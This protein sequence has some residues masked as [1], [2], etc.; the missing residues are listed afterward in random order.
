MEIEHSNDMMIENSPSMA[1]FTVDELCV[2]LIEGFNN[3]KDRFEKNDLSQ[4][5]RAKLIECLI[6]LR[7]GVYVF[8]NGILGK[9][10]NMKKCTPDRRN[11]LHIASS[12]LLV[13]APDTELER[14]FIRIFYT[15]CSCRLK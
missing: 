3:F 12:N 2:L 6:N 11:M 4:Q 1:Q 7:S 13:P 9:T 5:D 14:A 15:A 10:I 8:S